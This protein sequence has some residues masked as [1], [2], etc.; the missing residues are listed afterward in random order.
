MFQAGL[1]PLI[2]TWKG[3]PRFLSLPVIWC[4]F[5]ISAS[6]RC[7]LQLSHE[8]PWRYKDGHN[9]KGK[10]GPAGMNWHQD[11]IGY[12]FYLGL[13]IPEF[14]ILCILRDLVRAR[15]TPQQQKRGH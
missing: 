2:S 11:Q 12:T 9:L 4:N 5:V 13:T 10:K 7:T 3:W 14:E 6:L 8:P 1:P 15:G